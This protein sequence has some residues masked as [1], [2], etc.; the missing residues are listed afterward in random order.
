MDVAG[1]K[2]DPSF[3]AYNYFD[4]DY[5]QKFWAVRSILINSDKFVTIQR[6]NLVPSE[7]FKSF[8]ESHIGKYGLYFLYN[9][10][11]QLLYIGK[12]ISLGDRIVTSLRERDVNGYVCV[13]LTKHKADMHVYEPYY[14]IK[15]KPKLN[16]EFNDFDEYDEFGITLLPLNKSEL[17]KIYDEK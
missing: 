8:I 14:I 1:K 2:L 11:K 3:N 13:A 17:I 9:L 10:K 16:T 6:Y 4:R 7:N 15:E 5:L 12:S